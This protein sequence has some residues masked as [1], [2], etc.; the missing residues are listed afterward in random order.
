MYTDEEVLE[1][2][3]LEKSGK[4]F[5]WKL[6][7]KDDKM[8]VKFYS[9][10][11]QYT[12]IVMYIIKRFILLTEKIFSKTKVLEEKLNFIGKKMIKWRSNF[13]Q[14]LFSTSRSA[15][16]PTP[17]RG[18]AAASQQLQPLRGWLPLRGN[19]ALKPLIF[20]PISMHFKF[21]Q[22]LHS[23]D[24]STQWW[25]YC[26]V[27]SRVIGLHWSFWNTTAWFSFKS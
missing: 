22:S 13:I 11:S 17:L 21:K 16:S 14:G 7:Q 23:V 6:K 2:K 9:R 5:D 15:A 19:A 24:S 18:F 10:F 1:E 3:K 4:N 20:F 12:I 25:W 26:V 8:E 27:P